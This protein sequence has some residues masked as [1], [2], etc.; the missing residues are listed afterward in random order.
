MYKNLKWKG[1][2]SQSKRVKELLALPYCSFLKKEGGNVF[3]NLTLMD[4]RI[5]LTKV[6]RQGQ[7]VKP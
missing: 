7:R 5:I 1:G 6:N 4:G 3:L 2:T